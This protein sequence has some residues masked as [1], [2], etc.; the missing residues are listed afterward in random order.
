MEASP[1]LLEEWLGLELVL[2]QE[3]ECSHFPPHPF[4]HKLQRHFHIRSTDT[5]NTPNMKTWKG[6]SQIAH[7]LKEDTLVTFTLLCKSGDL[8]AHSIKF[9]TN[10]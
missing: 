8:N 5:S 9:Q 4:P 10:K 1:L 3:V 7:G 6:Q 2:K